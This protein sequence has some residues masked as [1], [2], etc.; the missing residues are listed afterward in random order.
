[1]KYI[2]TID[3]TIIIFQEHI[4]HNEFVKMFKKEDI[5][6]AGHV[7]F[8]IEDGYNSFSAGRIE[9]VISGDSYSLNLKPNY[10][11]DKMLIEIMLGLN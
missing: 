9:A 2:R 5:V 3:D 1:M 4:N 7:D 6:S 10:E 8:F 11:H